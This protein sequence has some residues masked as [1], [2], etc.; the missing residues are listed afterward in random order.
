MATRR[1]FPDWTA[2]VG[3]VAAVFNLSCP[4]CDDGGCGGLPPSTSWEAD[5]R[6]ANQIPPVTTNATGTGT[7]RLTTQSSIAYT[8]TITT[9]PATAITSAA[10]YRGSPSTN[11]DTVAVGLCGTGSPAPPCASLVAPGVLIA[12]I[13]EITPAQLNTLRA[14]GYYANVHTVGNPNG[15]IRGQVRNVAP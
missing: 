12:A 7:F 4:G 10:F 5:L 13:I 2:V 9:L 1:L 6:G 14:Y 15:E 8:I 11:S 3:V